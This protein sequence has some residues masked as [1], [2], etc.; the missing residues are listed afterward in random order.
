MPKLLLVSGADTIDLNEIDE[1]G[2]GFQAKSGVTGLGLPPVSVQWLEGAGD[3]AT[4]RRTRVQTRDIDL[5]IEIL[6]LDRTDLQA[7]LSRLALVLAGGCTLVLQ[8]GDGIQWHTDVWRVGG[9][10]YTY[11]ADSVGDREF[12]TVLTLRAGDPYFTSSVQQVRTISGAVSATSFL[13]SLAAMP[14]APSQ[15]IGSINLYNSGDAVA[16]PVWEVRGPGDHFTAT[17]PRGEVLKWNGTLA[18]G[19]KLIIDTK[20]GT[21]QDGTGA[22]RYDLLDTAPRFW[23]VEPGESTA[24]ASLLNTTSA[25]QITCS[26]YPRKWMVI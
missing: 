1:Y 25:S 15:A 20:K 26:W 14:V 10:E 13:S 2:V 5:P 8:N 19:E 23:T 24:G 11:G 4:Y 7:K 6:A 16:Y 9:G 21:V 3:G 12:Q 17:S 22:N 18:S